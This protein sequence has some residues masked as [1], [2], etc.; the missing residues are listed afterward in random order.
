M[1]D[2][3]KLT[4]EVEAT[5]SDASKEVEGLAQSLKNLQGAL[6]GLDSK[7]LSGMTSGLAGVKDTVKKSGLSS[8]TKQIKEQSKALSS[9]QKAA[10]FT[11]GAFGTGFK[12]VQT[13]LAGVSGAMK[14]LNN[15]FGLGKVTSSKFL[16]SL[17]RIAGYRIVRTIISSV[18][19]SAT[20]GLKNLANASSEANATLSQLSGGALTLQNAMGG[21]LY[22]V[23]AS[24][25]GL[26][27][28][29]IGAAVTAIN[30]IS[31][32]FSIL[33][34]RTTFK[35][36]TN[37]TKEFGSS[38]GAAGGAAKALKQELMGFDEINS[39]SPDTGGGGGGGGGGMLDYGSMFE[40]TPV[41]E[42]LL[43][44]VRN[45]D[46]TMLGE[47]MANKVN[48]ALGNIDW[49]KIK[50]G[51]YRFARSLVTF[52]NGFIG[53][54]DASII[55]D[56]IAGLVN[57]GLTFVNTFAY[58]TNWGLLGDKIKHAIV[59]AISQIKAEDVGRFIAAKT[60]M[61][62]RLIG[63]LLPSTSAEWSQIT[64]WIASIIN[65]AIDQINPAAIGAI[66][67][68]VIT[69]GLTLIKSLGEAG[70]F[71]NITSAIATAVTEAINNIS[72]DDIKAAAEA[73]L[74]EALRV[75]KAVFNLV[76]EIG[77]TTLGK[78]L[79]GYS[80][81]R[82]FQGAMPALG[83]KGFKSLGTSFQMAGALTFAFSA[84]AGIS[85]LAENIASGT[86]ISAD[87]VV[88]IASSAMKSIGYTVLKAAPYA[89]G[90][91]IG[92]G[93][94][95]DLINQFVNLDD[96]FGKVGQVV[97]GVV[98][99]T[100]VDGMKK[101]E[102]AT[103]N[104]QLSEESLAKVTKLTNGI[105]EK[106]GATAL[107]LTALWAGVAA[108]TLSMEEYSA[109]LKN[110]G[111][112]SGTTQTA[113]EGLINSFGVANTES[114]TTAVENVTSAVAAAADGFDNM[115]V[116]VDVP[117]PADD[118]AASYD[119]VTES[120]RATGEQAETLAT[121]I[122]TIPSDIVYNLELNNFDTIITQ[123]ETLASTINTSSTTGA[124]YFKTAFSGIPDWF[125]TNIVNPMKTKITGI[126]WYAIGNKAMGDFKRGL[127]SVKLPKF[128]VSWTTSSK[129]ATL[130][131]KDFTVSIPTPSI[132]LYAKG[133]FPDVGELFMANES[134]PELVGRIGSKPA[135]ANQDQIGDAIFKYMDAHSNENGTMDYDGMANALV[136]AMKAAGLGALYLDGKMIKRSLNAE[137]KRSGK[138]VLGY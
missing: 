68:K 131:G 82:L 67:G 49:G 72:E 61:G 103:A 18:T 30:W 10:S 98:G 42:S 35:K 119:A 4:L 78:V 76:V 84:I 107:D 97:T 130:F 46:F 115:P 80:L 104:A 27:N 118:V 70:I 92:L 114:A 132:E 100:M 48:N 19:S 89:G 123:F 106:G 16:T 14:M 7:K 36:A 8:S 101:L 129:T 77:D 64:D 38:L 54:I 32:L 59:T 87:D 20:T 23:I 74:K 96:T 29:V 91:L 60:V 5:S 136:R 79:T 52:L 69:G 112:T 3:E 2:L 108:G 88:G 133:G 53:K 126:S 9:L 47:A 117:K 102:E 109:V 34:G 1:A 37:S 45:A 85:D 93:F 62:V 65:T 25:I 55:G 66:I 75:I 39:L 125:G 15:A 71:S 81:F 13:Q 22:S 94:G 128:S 90:I 105:I 111:I 24:I 11:K 99:G 56:T 138:P 135:V 120:M 113:V 43:E 31:M 41:D 83:L 63:G 51:A 50:T 121:K 6:S 12:G 110:L 95:I 127:K 44:M 26:L 116:A 28:S 58:D 33:G 17:A 134:G 122:I 57:A 124:T 73:V 40:E 137:A 21:A 86:S